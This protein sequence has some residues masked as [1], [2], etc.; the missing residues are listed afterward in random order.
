MLEQTITTIVKELQQL[1]K[2]EW[3]MLALEESNTKNLAHVDAKTQEHLFGELLKDAE[4]SISEAEQEEFF[5]TVLIHYAHLFE[6]PKDESLVFKNMI[7]IQR[8]EMD[9]SVLEVAQ[10]LSPLLMYLV[11]REIRELMQRSSSEDV[12][13]NSSIVA[14]QEQESKRIRFCAKY[15]KTTEDSTARFPFHCDKF[16]NLKIWRDDIHYV[17][18]IKLK[19]S[20]LWDTLHSLQELE[21]HGFTL[22]PERTNVIDLQIKSKHFRQHISDLIVLLDRLEQNHLTIDLANPNS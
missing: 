1:S 17:S 11:E 8:K 18:S 13:W 19:C 10:I 9:Q 14:I 6:F 2:E 20:M 21:D 7:Q 4:T 12:L 22:V 5:Y 3:Y 15:E 16:L